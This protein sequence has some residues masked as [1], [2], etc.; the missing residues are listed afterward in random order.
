MRVT[1]PLALLLHVLF[2]VGLAPFLAQQ[3]PVHNGDVSLVSLSKPTYPALA[4]AARIGGEV[5]LELKVR[6]D[7]S[8][9]SVSVV[10]GHPMLQ[11]TALKSAQAST[12]KCADC[13]AES[14][15]YALVYSFRLETDEEAQQNPAL[16]EV[17]ISQDRHRITVVTGPQ[18]IVCIYFSYIS[19]R[20]AKCLY[21]WRCGSRWGGEDYYNYRVRS[22]KCL[23]L[24]KCGLKPKARPVQ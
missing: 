16:D 20:S 11:E 24:W 7:G 10:S 9:E 21:L 17:Q 3:A 8:V 1:V 2:P 23:G 13:G 19:V 14:V 4:R 18:P 22:P 5:K 15:P 6:S 12:F